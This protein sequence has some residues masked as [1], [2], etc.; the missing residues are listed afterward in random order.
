MSIVH[1]DLHT[2]DGCRFA[3]KRNETDGREYF[4]VHVY[5]D[6]NV[7]QSDLTLYTDRAGIRKLS[8]AI[9]GLC[10]KEEI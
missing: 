1:I 2:E 7:A 9:N 3:A 4:T 8:D 10:E 6:P 5:S